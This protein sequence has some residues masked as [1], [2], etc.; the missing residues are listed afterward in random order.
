MS[1]LSE[2][3]GRAGGQ[4]PS[5]R[6]VAVTAARIVKSLRSNFCAATQDH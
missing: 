6:A 4:L 5:A 1:R 3:S 2:A